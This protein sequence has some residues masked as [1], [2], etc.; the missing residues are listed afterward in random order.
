MIEMM[1]SRISPIIVFHSH[2]RLERGPFGSAGLLP[3]EVAFASGEIA[4]TTS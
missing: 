2:M 1:A 4:M 3:G